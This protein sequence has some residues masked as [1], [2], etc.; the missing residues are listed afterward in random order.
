MLN[1][2]LDKLGTLLSKSIMVSAWFP[3][4][5]CIFINSSLLYQHD[6]RFRAFIEAEQPSTAAGLASKLLMIVV[7]L[8]IGTYILSTLQ[9]LLRELIEGRRWY[10]WIADPFL[11]IQRG[12]YN[13]ITDELEK[14]MTRATTF[15][16]T[17]TWAAELRAATRIGDDKA[18]NEFT[19]LATASDLANLQSSR[20]RGKMIDLATLRRVKVDLE[21]ELRKNSAS[22][23]GDNNPLDELNRKF[24]DLVRYAVDRAEAQATRLHTLRAANFPDDDD[25]APTAAGNI[26]RTMV[27]YAY[28]RYHFNL[29]LLWTRL[30]KVMQADTAFYPVVQDSKAQL[31]FAVSTFWLLLVSAVVW[32]GII[33]TTGSSITLF[34]LAVIG[35]PLAAAVAYAFAVVSYRSFTDVVRTSVDLYRLDLLK[36]LHLP[37]PRSADVERAQWEDVSRALAYGELIDQRYEHAK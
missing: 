32:T 37:L 7:I 8:V 26:A 11:G 34:L 33:T 21:G 24:A 30:Q 19:K 2:L 12:K 27:T 18:K 4:L 14:A 28:S 6:S 5:I 20:L 22:I 25:L 13:Q 35:L 36:T 16:E 10:D 15:D 3:V 17:Q 9:P 31:D 29:D 1:S 23:D